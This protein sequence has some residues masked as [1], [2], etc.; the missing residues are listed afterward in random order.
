MDRR[1]F[2]TAVLAAL[3]L[4]RIAAAPRQDLE[5]LRAVDRAQK[6]RPQT[7][8]ATSRIAPVTEPGTPLV[9]HGLVVQRDGQTPAAG[10]VVFGYHTDAN[11]H[12]DVP[13]AGAHSWRLRGWAKTGADGRFEFT[14]IRPAPYPSG[15]VAAHVHLM[16]ER[17]EGRWQA[18][19]IV[20]DGDPLIGSAER[21][22]SA[23]AGRFGAIRPVDVRDGVQHVNIDLR[24][25]G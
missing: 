21:E 5:F 20:F 25:D 2:L 7:L 15:R 16:V 23:S 14:T 8:G 3:P 18:A 10:V 24:L 17:P 11:G 1:N 6:A 9:I 22:E 13:E 19:G 4:A 12:Y